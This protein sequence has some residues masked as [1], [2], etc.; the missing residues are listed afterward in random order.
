MAIG[1]A[2]EIE[3]GLAPRRVERV[4]LVRAPTLLGYR[5]TQ[6]REQSLETMQSLYWTSL[7]PHFDLYSSIPANSFPIDP[8]TLM[9][10]MMSDIV[11]TDTTG[12]P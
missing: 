9:Y 2:S 8:F 7:I 3:G 11:I 5:C 6:R 12:T 1:L 10:A 4:T